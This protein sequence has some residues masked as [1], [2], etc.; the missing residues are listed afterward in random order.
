MSEDPVTAAEGRYLRLVRRGHWEF[1]E[2]VGVL[3]VAVLVPITDH[4]EIV[5][6]E[7]YRIPVQRRMIELP[8]GLVGDEPGSADEGLLEAANRELEEET[9]YRASTLDL[10]LR[11]PSSGGMTSEVVTFVKAT[12]LA[13]VGEGGGVEDED[14]RVHVVPVDSVGKWLQDRQTDGCLLDP[15]I[16]AGLYLIG[17]S[18]A[19]AFCG[20]PGERTV[21]GTS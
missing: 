6:V 15:K 19:S 17:A 1:V 13:R 14:I 4:R 9:G 18:G 7:Q 5:L 10:L 11:A 12:G 8:A 21:A 16:F 2:R 20:R 3:D